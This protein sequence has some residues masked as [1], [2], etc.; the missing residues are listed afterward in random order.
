MCT[1]GA[2]LG[3]QGAG[4]AQQAVGSYYSARAQ[5]SALNLQADIAEINA[6]AAL[7]QADAAM[8]AGERQGAQI[9]LR[10]GQVKASQRAAMAAN[11]IDLGVGSAVAVQTTTDAMGQ[12]DAAAVDSN[13]VRA[14]WGLRTEATNYGNQARMAR[15]SAS[16]LSPVGSAVTSLLGGATSV[17]ASWYDLKKA[18]AFETLRPTDDPIKAYGALNGWW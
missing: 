6:K 14:A 9:K 8:A 4:A 1:P 7:S 5:Q 2:I 12:I 11:G 15:A 3:I 18:G 16:G 13:A 10:A 17:A